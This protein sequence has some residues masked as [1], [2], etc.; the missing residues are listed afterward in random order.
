MPGGSWYELS[1]GNRIKLITDAACVYA[2]VKLINWSWESNGPESWPI[3]VLIIAN[4]TNFLQGCPCLTHLLHGHFSLKKNREAM[5]LGGRKFLVN[6]RELLVCKHSKHE[7]HMSVF[8]CKGCTFIAL[9]KRRIFRT[10]IIYLFMLSLLRV[11]YFS[12]KHC[13]P[14]RPSFR[15]HFTIFTIS[16]T[17]I[18]SKWW[19]QLGKK[20][21]TPSGGA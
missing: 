17:I 11:I 2:Y 6:G 5:F 14:S 15:L 20:C 18:W 13:F 9:V 1:W 10:V 19:S 7:W 8:E 12:E 16:V 21:S 4:V 3:L